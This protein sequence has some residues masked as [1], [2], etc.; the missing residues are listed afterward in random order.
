MRYA[1]TNIPGWYLCWGVALHKTRPDAV[2]FFVG[3]RELGH[4]HPSG[5]VDLPL[6]PPIGEALVRA[7]RV[8][9]HRMTESGWYTHQI[10][11]I[12]DMAEAEW[13]LAL[14]HVLHTMR[15]EGHTS[16]EVVEELRF[17]ELDP[18]LREALAVCEGCWSWGRDDH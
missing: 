6:P 12:P 10:R 3:D 2:G 18:A 8:T 14:A 7:G 17:L 16:E 1:T 9:H 11:G 5:H 4:I 15:R 13:L